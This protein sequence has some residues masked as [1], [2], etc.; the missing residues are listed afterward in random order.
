MRKRIHS[1]FVMRYLNQKWLISNRFERLID[2]DFV[3]NVGN[4]RSRNACGELM[5]RRELLR[6]IFGYVCNTIKRLSNKTLRI[7]AIYSIKHRRLKLAKAYD[8]GST[9]RSRLPSCHRRLVQ[10][11]PRPWRH[12]NL[13]HEFV[14]VNN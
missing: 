4:H 6:W 11:P 10:E 13:D 5:R 1:R 7:Q 12:F 3:R 9:Y 14:I 8:T 2:D